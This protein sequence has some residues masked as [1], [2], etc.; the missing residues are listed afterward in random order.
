[1]SDQGARL[2][3]ALRLPPAERLGPLVALGREALEANGA[4][5]PTARRRLI[6]GLVVLLEEGAGMPPERVALGEVLGWLGDP[7]IR[8]AADPRYWAKI[9]GMSI[10]A[11]PV[12]NAE[13]RAWVTGG[14]Y[15]SPASWSE[16]GWA[17]RSRCPDPWPEI[18]A[19]E[20][21]RTFLVPNQ[22]VVGVTW[23]EA[24]AFA[25]AMGAR[26][27]T[28]DERAWAMRGAQKRPYPWG[29]PFGT[30]NANTREE[31]LGRPVAVGLF[32]RDRTPDGVGDLAGNA[33]EWLGDEI[34]DNRLIHPGAWDQP[35]MASWAKAKD[36]R[37]PDDRSA[38][39]GFRLAKD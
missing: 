20:E 39:I 25:R 3:D 26:L 7:R 5:E 18:A 15:D 9:D 21:S 14:G 33:A 6:D 22:P 23:W 13:F 38:A 24:D 17:W 27:P 37:S 28:A 8:D 16:A 19:R 35:S 31:V 4:S 2:D 11:W 10:A 29:E 30:G 1:V 32:V 36:L 12:T 34:G